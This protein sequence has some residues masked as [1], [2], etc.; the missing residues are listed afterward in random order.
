MSKVKKL[1]L[2]SFILI[3][4]FIFNINNA[5]ALDIK[6]KDVKVSEKSDNVVT[7]DIE[8]ND[9][10]TTTNIEFK[11]LND[12]ITYKIT[13]KNND[14]KKYN[15]EDIIDDNDNENI[16]VTYKYDD[17][18]INAKDTQDIYVTL[19]YDK[20]L[21]NKRQITL[22]DLTITLNLVDESG[23]KVTSN[24]NP[25]TGDNII[26]FIVLFVV[27]LLILLFSVILIKRRKG[28]G[29][30]LLLL[31]IPCVIMAKVQLKFN[32][33]FTTIKVDGEMLPY[34]VSV[35]DSNGNITDRTVTYGDPIGELPEPTKDGYTFDKYE[36]QDGNEVDEDTIVEGDMTIT[37]KF[38]IVEYNITYD[39]NGGSASNPD[40]YTVE[41]EITLNNPTKTGYTFSGWTGSNGNDLQTRVTIVNSTGN[42][43]YV[44]NYSANQDTSYTVI[45]KYPKLDGTYEEVTENLHGATD[46]SV[47][48]AL[49][50]KE[51]FTGPEL[52]TITI[53][54]DGTSTVTYTYTRNN[55]N[56]SIT[57]RTYVDSE[58]T[59]NGFYPY[60]TE[61][62]VK[63][64][65]RAG[66]TFKWSDDNT[67]YERTF[68]L[69]GDKTLTPIYTANTNTPYTVIHR[70]P[71]LDG[72]YEEVTQNLEGT[73]DDEVT[74]SVV[75]KEGFD[76][77]TPQ[78]V[79]ISGDGNRVVT[80]TYTRKTYNFAITDRTYV[81]NTSTSNGEYPHGTTI[82]VKAQEREGYTFKWSDDNTNY[83]RTFELTETTSLTP[84]YTRITYTVSFD[85]DG[86]N[87]ISTQT[88][89]YGEKATRPDNPTKGDYRFI[90]WY[91]D[92]NYT[93]LYDFD[94]EIYEN[95]TIYAKW[96]YPV[97]YF[98]LPPDWYGNKVYAY[99]FSDT[100][101]MTWPG[102]EMTLVDE[103]KQIYSYVIPNE[104]LDL[105]NKIV[106]TNGE[107]V[108]NQ[109]NNLLLNGNARQTMDVTISNEMY[110]KIFVP[111]LYSGEGTRVLFRNASKNWVQ[112][113]YKWN[114][115]N[116]SQNNGWPGQEFTDSIN[117]ST[118]Y[119][120]VEPNYNMMIFNKGRGGTG[121]QTA[122]LNVPTNQDMVYNINNSGP[123]RIFYFGG[124]KDY[125]EWNDTGYTNWTSDDGD[126]NKFRDS[127]PYY[128]ITL[129]PNGGSIDSTFINILKGNNIDTL[130]I[131]V[132]PSGKKFDGWYTSLSDGIKV[133]D[134]YTPTGN[135]TLYAKYSDF[136]PTSFATDDWATIVEAV[137]TGDTSAYNVGD[138]KTVEIDMDNDGTKESYTL[139]LANKTI[140]SNC[141][142]D[143]Y[144]Q[145]ACGFVV[146]FTDALKRGRISPYTNASSNG[147][148][149]KGGW[150]YS[151]IRSY[152]NNELLSKLPFDLKS[153][154]SDT[155]VI[156]GHGSTDSSNFTTTDKLYLLSSV[157]V[158]GSTYYDSVS[159]SQ[160]RQLDYYNNNNVTQSNTGGAI[161]NYNNSGSSWW[162]RTPRSNGKANYVYVSGDGSTNAYL[163]SGDNGIAPA[164]RISF[165]NTVT[166]DANG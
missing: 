4:A 75:G 85:T 77:P 98:Q 55:Y 97:V 133:D 94:T 46:T 123:Y 139:R 128:N 107:S 134:T 11:E 149:N 20:K 120:V 37:P 43:N 111:E 125:T 121:N 126:Y 41:D 48:P 152:A 78:T 116:S 162:L 68:E 131:P 52:E 72:T 56:F 59:S 74:P 119:T 14:N 155:R 127:Y 157:E 136:N 42:L 156:S 34:T 44:A 8:F 10:S 147:D 47:T 53:K 132:P 33:K 69:T 93:T 39:L 103:D 140:T 148:G 61:I 141:T 92:D 54:G 159:T 99:L 91:T 109:D 58:S 49:I 17:K 51:G 154:I 165:S 73:T 104:E 100:G 84:V 63:A 101:G 3:C 38:N 22:S 13:L 1:F 145:T 110:G 117:S 106:F 113:I 25:K 122:N 89:N 138:T 88:I 96:I 62:T 50:E 31:L 146:E 15:I 151:E 144:S 76:S 130:P 32:I 143:N 118:Y 115:S 45:H 66:Y 135:V 137:R 2:F 161:K 65:E 26:W 158:W 35:K 124:W 57:D 19:K 153:S 18:E 80:Y 28:K 71:N 16:K 166:L 12:Y 64:Q 29:L 150:E 70:Y 83:E 142:S 90:D 21:I 129:N 82:T 67:N 60:E 24:I 5:F 87:D 105:Y 163:S 36:D 86:G 40:K 102:D 95:K 112:H 6:I 9:N 164:F 30:L 23:N 114:S 160:T 108:D 7:S 79:T 27:A 81:D